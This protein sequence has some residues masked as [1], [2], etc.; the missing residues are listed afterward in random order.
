MGAALI[1]SGFLIP[2]I[3]LL[4]F[5]NDWV[6]VKQVGIIYNIMNADLRFYE[7]EYL[8]KI[9]QDGYVDIKKMNYEGK[10]YIDWEK[11]SEEYKEDKYTIP[12]RYAAGSGLISIILGSFFY[13]GD[14]IMQKFERFIIYPMLFIA[15]FFS[16]ADDGVQ[17]TTAQQVY[18]EIIAKSISIVN[19]EGELLI[20]LSR[21]EESNVNKNSGRI[22]II[23]YDG[24]K[25]NIIPGHISLEQNKN[26]LK[27]QSNGIYINEYDNKKEETNRIKIGNNINSNYTYFFG[28]G[29]YKNNIFHNNPYYM[30][31]IDNLSVMLKSNSKSGLLSIKNDHGD[32]LIYLGS[33]TNSH[34]LINIYDK[35][36]EDYRSYTYK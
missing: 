1:I 7:S 2:L 6:S 31:N 22:K 34:G 33:S 17:Q 14:E 13:K 26:Y 19:D 23:G 3:L 15:I 11:T 28:I 36:G 24:D 21:H 12:F 9:E 10:I 20:N 8:N 32:D 35:Y 27:A 4:F 29:I 25:T 5:G 16:F 30:D 18:D